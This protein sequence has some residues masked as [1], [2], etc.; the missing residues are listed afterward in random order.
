MIF[1]VCR[2]SHNNGEPEADESDKTVRDK[3]VSYAL[4]YNLSPLFR[5]KQEVKEAVSEPLTRRS[6]YEP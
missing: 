2:Q 6:D 3:R 5:N 4:H 1:R